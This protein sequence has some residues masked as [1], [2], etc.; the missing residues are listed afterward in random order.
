M[1]DGN[2]EDDA[3]STNVGAATMRIVAASCADETFS[4]AATAG[5]DASLV[6]M[7]LNALVTATPTAAAS[8]LE[9]ADA[10]ALMTVLFAAA[11]ALT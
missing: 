6:M 1:V 5:K 9:L 10:P 2:G 8:A 4:A 7:E 3:A 11:V